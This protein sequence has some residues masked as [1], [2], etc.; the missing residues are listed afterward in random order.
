MSIYAKSIPQSYKVLNY[1]TLPDG[2]TFLEVDCQSYDAFT[3]LPG[4]MKFNGMS[5]GLTGW[6]SDTQLAYYKKSKSFATKV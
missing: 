3:A 4:G 5:Y 2:E 1:G 6:N